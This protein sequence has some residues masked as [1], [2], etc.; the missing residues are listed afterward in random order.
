MMSRFFQLLEQ[1]ERADAAACR[2]ESCVSRHL[3]AYCEGMG[4][5]PSLE[6]IGEAKQRRAAARALFRELA[7]HL[8]RQR[9]SLPVL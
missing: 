4:R 1:W 3:D 2:A 7:V 5:A 8:A 9:R 6:E